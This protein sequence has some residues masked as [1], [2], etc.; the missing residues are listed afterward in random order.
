LYMELWTSPNV[1]TAANN[2][3]ADFTLVYEAQ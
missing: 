1:W 3:V 2:C